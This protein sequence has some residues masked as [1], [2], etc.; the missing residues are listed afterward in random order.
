M[1]PSALSLPLLMQPPALITHEVDGDLLADALFPPVDDTDSA[2]IPSS[3]ETPTPAPDSDVDDDA[4]V[5]DPIPIRQPRS[6][7]LKRVRDNLEPQIE[8]WVLGWSPLRTHFLMSEFQVLWPFTHRAPT[9]CSPVAA[10]QAPP[11][12]PRSP[13]VL[14]SAVVGVYERPWLFEEPDIVFVER[15]T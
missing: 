7:L 9:L 1:G 14:A 5:P 10:L 4:V 2:E 11:T 3:P 15:E 12:A 6:Q 13:R 8:K